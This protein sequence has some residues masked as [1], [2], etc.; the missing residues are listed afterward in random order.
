MQAALF[1]CEHADAFHK[2]LSQALVSHIPTVVFGKFDE[3]HE[4]CLV[5]FANKRLGGG[6]LGYG[7]VQEEIMFA[8]RFDAGALCARSLL[9][10]PEDPTKEPVAS[11]FSMRPNEAWIIKGCPRFAHLPWYGRVPAD[12]QNKLKLLNPDDDQE[13]APTIICVDAIKASFVR[14]ERKHLDMMLLK[15]YC[16]F[17]AAHSDPL[18]GGETSVATG[19][20]GCGAF[21]NNECVMFVIQTL[22]ANMAGVKLT[23]HVLGDG[24]RL[25]PAFEFLETV[26]LNK[27]TVAQAMDRLQVL[28]ASDDAWRSKFR[29]PSADAAPAA[30]KR[31]KL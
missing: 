26:M 20:W 8:E 7:H 9:E 16:G 31:S 24:Y 13:S 15:A 19:S 18:M 5:D 25:A 2:T 23:H 6:W 4:R 22:A 27:I 17:A 14:Y 11:P 29:P 10:M 28:C 21:Y 1:R 12:W 3:K 30:G